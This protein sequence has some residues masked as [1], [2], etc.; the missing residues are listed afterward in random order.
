MRY[1]GTELTKT[2]TH[3]SVHGAVNFR[4]FKMPE[5]NEGKSCG[6]ECAFCWIAAGKPKT[7]ESAKPTE[8]Q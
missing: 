6:Y 2:A 7:D 4:V 5:P 8:R 1:T 3:C